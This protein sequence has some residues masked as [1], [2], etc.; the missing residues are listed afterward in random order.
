MVSDDSATYGGQDSTGEDSTGGD[1]H[2][3]GDAG[4]GATVS[5]VVDGGPAAAA[6]LGTGDVI[7]GIGSDRVTSASEV[8]SLLTTYGVGDKVK[9]TW[10]D[11]SGDSHTRTVAL[12]ASPVA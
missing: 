5:G 1:G 10:T 11:T 9:I 3:Q 7:T 12:A 6:G 8:G 4:I 2:G